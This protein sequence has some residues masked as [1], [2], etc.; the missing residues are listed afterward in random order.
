MT[1]VLITGATGFIGRHLVRAA[2][3]QGYDVTCLVQTTSAA[4]RLD[5]LG[6]RRVC[7]DVTDRNSLATAIQRQDVVFTDEIGSFET[8]R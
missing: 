2:G 1:K 8:G 5:G 4:K 7:G 3:S 6:A